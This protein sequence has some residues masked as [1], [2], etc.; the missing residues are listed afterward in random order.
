MQD[1]GRPLIYEFGDF[2]LDAQG[3][4]LYRRD[5]GET[6]ALTPRAVLLL[7]TLVCS[8][9]R[10]L[11]KEEL[12]DR[13]WAGLAV[14]EGNLSQTIFVLRK[15]LGE[16]KK[17]PKFI[18]TVPGRGYQF[19]AI[20][21]E[22]ADERSLD[23]N[24]YDRF[25]AMPKV[26]TAAYQSYVQA[27]SFWNKRTESGLKQA[28]AHFEEAIR[29][30][31]NFAFA[32]S[33]LADSHRMLAEYYSAALPDRQTH[34]L[35]DAERVNAELSVAHT[36]LGYARAFHDWDWA[37]AES[38]FLKAIELD[39]AS[40]TA[41]Q[42]YADLLNVLGRFNE[43]RKHFSKAIALAPDSAMAATGLASYFYTK[44]DSGSLI[45]QAKRIIEI[46]PDFGYGYFYLG[47]GLEFGGMEA[48]SVN[49]LAIAATKF[50]EPDEIGEELKAAYQQN[51]MNGVWHKRLEQYETRPHLKNYPRYLKSL[52]P[53]RLGDRETS[54][55]WLEQAFE[56]RDR[57]IIYAKYEPLLEPLRGDRRFKE[58]IKRIGLS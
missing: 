21:T 57:G 7:M 8:K 40:A 3:Q 4:R 43:S 50:G 14:E 15:A 42:W 33:G 44:R 26:S 41:H 53:V 49:A 6:V 35:P 37:G 17:D 29:Q 38:E 45:S 39:P 51:G 55:A 46:D 54:L 32:Y 52:V 48:E 2:R 18:M 16:G 10:L 25:A 34:A 1:L 27:R 36:T 30:D 24:K 11:T 23:V 56:Q 28:V 13:V 9:G 19:I 20:V 58:L 47:F 12:L 31:P 5:S 22:S